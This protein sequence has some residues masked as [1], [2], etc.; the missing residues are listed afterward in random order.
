MYISVN[1]NTNKKKFW[2]FLST[3]YTIWYRLSLKTISRYCPF[4][5]THGLCPWWA[6]WTVLTGSINIDMESFFLLLLMFKCTLDLKIGLVEGEVKLL[7]SPPDSCSNIYLRHLGY[8]SPLFFFILRCNSWT[9]VWQKTQ[10]FS[11]MLFTVFLLA[12]FYGL[13]T[14][15]K[16]C[17]TRQ[18][19]SIPE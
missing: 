2:F 8:S 4:K 6:R 11:T 13:Q 3:F 1:N 18:L 14:Y 5:C 10:V 9:S 7:P 19:E 15:K 12:D 17:E 16:I